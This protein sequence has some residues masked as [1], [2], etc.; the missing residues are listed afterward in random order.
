MPRIQF[1]RDEARSE[2]FELVPLLAGSRRCGDLAEGS[3]GV[4]PPAERD[5]I[6]D[7][8]TIQN[9]LKCFSEDLFRKPQ[10][11]VA[12]KVDHPEAEKKFAD[13]KARLTELNAVVLPISSI[14]GKGLNDL[15]NH[16]GKALWGSGKSAEL[17]PTG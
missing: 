3:A 10:L 14:T 1:P 16:I 6:A 4:V 15:I 12:S 9:E 2:V 11:L 8:Q 17:F 13:Y 5:P 7:Y